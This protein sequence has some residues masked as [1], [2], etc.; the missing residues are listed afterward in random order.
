M[1]AR[2][3]ENGKPKQTAEVAYENAHVAAQNQLERI[4]ELLFDL[5][6]DDEHPINWGHVGS[7]GEVN[8]ILAE[9]VAFLD[10]TN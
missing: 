7:L 1:T 8:R 5:P 2:Q 6:A 9:L 3:K 10:G 4:R